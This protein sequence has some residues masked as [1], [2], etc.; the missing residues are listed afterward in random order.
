MFVKPQHEQG[1]VI[2]GELYAILA[3]VF[4]EEIL[5][6]LETHGTLAFQVD[7]AEGV[8]GIVVLSSFVDQPLLVRFYLLLKLPNI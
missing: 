8:D 4:G 1:K 5:E 6:L 3:Q 2:F 7:E